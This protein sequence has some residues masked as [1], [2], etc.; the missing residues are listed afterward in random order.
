MRAG[1]GRASRARTGTSICAGRAGRVSRATGVS[2]TRA[3]SCD[4]TGEGFATAR[5]GLAGAGTAALTPAFTLAGVRGFDIATRAGGGVVRR[6][7][8]AVSSA[9]DVVGGG[10]TRRTSAPRVPEVPAVRGLEPAARALSAFVVGAPRCGCV[11]VICVRVIAGRSG[12]ATRAVWARSSPV[13]T[14]RVGV[15]RRTGSSFAPIRVLPS[16]TARGRP[17][18]TGNESVEGDWFACAVRGA[19]RSVRGRPRS[20]PERSRWWLRPS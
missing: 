18:S 15:A 8:G 17:G 12:A 1:G 2:R 4:R 3:G 16:R 14:E 19:S 5:A 10:S 6:A 20:P 9:D 13:S 7:T 11:R